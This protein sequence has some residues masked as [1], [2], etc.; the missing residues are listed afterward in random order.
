M[1]TLPAA[2]IV[3]EFSLSLLKYFLTTVTKTTLIIILQLVY[4][5]CRFRDILTYICTL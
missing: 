3:I 1:Q 4:Y 5:M 2:T